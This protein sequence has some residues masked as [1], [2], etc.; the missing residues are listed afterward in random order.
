M[1]NRLARSTSP[2]LQQHADNP[3]DWHEWGEEAFAEAR[4]RDVPV[5]VSIGYSAC[6]WCHVMAHE[7]FEDPEI[8]RVM[9][10]GFVNI[11]VDREERPDV[12][13]VY[14]NAT[15]AMT[16]RGGWPMTVF[17]DG[18]RRP[19]FAGTYFPPSPRHGMPSFRQVLAAITDAWNN[20]R[21][22]LGEQ[23]D[24]LTE[25]I[26]H[27]IPPGPDL[28]GLDSLQRAYR[29]L[30]RTYDPVHGGLGSAPKFPQQPALDYLLRITGRS[31]APRAGSMVRQ[32]L[33]KMASGGI[34]DHV[35][36]GFARYSVDAEWLVPHFEKMLYD[37]AQLARLYLRAGQVFSSP[38]FT[39]VALDTLTYID[40]DLGL[41][42]G[43]FASAEDADSEGREGAFYVWT[44][45]QI[46]DVLGDRAE[47]AVR[48][49]GITAEGNFEG[50]NVLHHARL[51]SE[52]AEEMAIDLDDARRLD[53]EVRR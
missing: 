37:N 31:W 21:T 30:E 43:G 19:F 47:F 41:E 34:H 9:N 6:H 28:P 2:Y 16:G 44:E 14:M 1:P 53:S 27:S 13:A 29:Q 24:R 39:Q 22:E 50:A 23:A 33:E 20:R 18:D 7:S 17:V 42:G 3:V 40:R 52:V 15:Q 36:G 35:G 11:K 5:L 10:E 48:R 26:S 51:L 38:W 49:F 46:R 8:A 32:T 12:D 45:T 25:A 4:R